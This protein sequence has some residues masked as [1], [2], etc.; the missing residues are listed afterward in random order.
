MLGSFLKEIL[1]DIHQVNAVNKNRIK[2]DYAESFTK[3]AKMR[4]IQKTNYSGKRPQTVGGAKGD[5]T[6]GGD[7]DDDDDTQMRAQR[8]R[9]MR[10]QK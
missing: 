7:D 1:T 8:S 6:S 4:C 9:H 3:N 2:L 5:E 10:A